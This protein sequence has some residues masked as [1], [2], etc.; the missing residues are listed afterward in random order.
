MPFSLSL[1]LVFSRFSLTLRL[2]HIVDGLQIGHIYASDI[3]LNNNKLIH[4]N[5]TLVCAKRLKTLRV[6]HN[7]LPKQAFTK[8]LLEESALSLIA[9]SHNHFQQKD[10]QDLPGYEAYEQRFT[11]NRRKGVY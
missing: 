10:F 1:L 7:A 3:N 9:F 4:L 5:P 6:E 11:A 2:W 8:E